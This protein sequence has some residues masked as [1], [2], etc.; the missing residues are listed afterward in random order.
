MKKLKKVA[1]VL[2]AMTFAMT[3]FTACGGS[4]ETKETPAADDVPATEA[5]AA[6]EAP[7]EAPA[8]EAP[9]EAPATEAPAAADD[10][11]AAAADDDADADADDEAAA[12]AAELLDA[13]SNTVWVG[14]DT[15]YTCYVLAFGEDEIYFADDLGGVVE[16]YWDITADASHIFIYSDAE[17]TDEIGG[18]DW[19][20]DEE[21]DTMVI[22]DTV[23]MAQTDADSIDAAVEEL[24][25]MSFAKTV[26]EA[27]NETYWFGTDST[28]SGL[29]LAMFE[30]KMIWASIDNEG[31]PVV[32]T[33]YWGMDY[34]NITLYNAGYQPVLEMGW[35]ISEDMSSLFLTIDGEEIEMSQTTEDDA[36]TFIGAAVTIGEVEPADDADDADDA[37]AGDDDDYSSYFDG[38]LWAGQDDEGT[39][40]GLIFDGDT[41]T[42]AALDENNE[43]AGGEVE[44]AADV[45]YLYLGDAVFTWEMPD[46]ETLVLTGEDGSVTTFVVF[47]G[48]PEELG[49]TMAV[50]AAE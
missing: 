35:D 9:T 15:D 40:A 36:A 18:F 39:P 6:T 45:D 11:N 23:V 30:E 22:M 38:T 2:A 4:E 16:G 50:M 47:D 24:E 42:L 41:A 48:T 1:A 46:D 25:K 28:D 7:T 10:D 17:L 14:M 3:A 21:S 20:Y 31:N 43:L 12:L 44:W 29:V 37:G 5:P 19:E 13:V 8:T 32:E 27:L 33:L 34:D 49:A 26:A